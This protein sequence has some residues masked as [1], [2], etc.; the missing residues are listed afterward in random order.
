M[1]ERLVGIISR[2]NLVRALAATERAASTASDND[3][4]II[5]NRV[6]DELIRKRLLDELS[7]MELAQTVWAA[8]VI[9]KD[10][11]VDLWLSDDQLPEQRR[12]VHIAA[13]NTAG[14]RSVE[15]HI[16]PGTPV[17]AF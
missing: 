6:Q 9:V 11:K 2:A 3:E 4:Q 15:E 7:K 13:E 1:M 16:V 5:R 10:Q 12:A 17:P 14:V 8:D